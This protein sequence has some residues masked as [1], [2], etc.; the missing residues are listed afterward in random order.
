[1]MCLLFVCVCVLYCNKCTHFA[2]YINVI[3][4]A[5]N[6]NITYHIDI[7][8]ESFAGDMHKFCPVV[9]VCYLLLINGFKNRMSSNYEQEK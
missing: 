2:A 7:D 9:I 5:N 4:G 3:I 1:M 6:I 8:V